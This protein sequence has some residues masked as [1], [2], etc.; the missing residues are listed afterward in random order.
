MTDPLFDIRTPRHDLPL[1]F[2]G[3]AQ[4]ESFVNEV[5]ARVD[6]LLHLAIEG[7]AASPPGS[8]ADGQCWLVAAAPTGDWIGRAGQIA[9]REAG[10]W[11]FLQPRDGMQALNKATGQCIRFHGTWKIAAKPATPTGG[12][13]VDAEA[14]AAIAALVAALV[15]AGM[16]P[17]A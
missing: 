3:Q 2:A 5:A 4:K 10:N 8:P 17:A 15:T 13:T 12:T 6:A 11:L 16:I 1:L 14:R 9:A 7:E